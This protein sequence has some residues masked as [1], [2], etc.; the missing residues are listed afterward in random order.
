MSNEISEQASRL[1]K[2]RLY[3][4]MTRH[5]F[6]DRLGIS[7]YTIRSWENG[8]KNFSEKSITR[9]IKALKNNVNF[10]CKFEWIMY[11]NGT[12]PISLHEEKNKQEIN[13][14][15]LN[16]LEDKIIK[17]VV[18]F[19]NLNKE[20]SVVAVTDDRFQPIASAGDYIGFLEIKAKV[21]KKYIGNIML[22]VDSEGSQIFGV[23]EKIENKFFISPFKGR[24]K[25]EITINNKIK[26]FLLI[27]FRKPTQ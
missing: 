2:I 4:G 11:G 18:T 5:Q 3:L 12:S 27:W 24:K 21:L 25:Q 20:A 14:I 8:A 10:S 7:Q 23:L 15:E 19:K 22:W 9:V 1:K 26:L 17:E 16:A 13:N 6:G